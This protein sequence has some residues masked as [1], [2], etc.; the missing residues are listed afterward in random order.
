MSETTDFETARAERALAWSRYVTARPSQAPPESPL[1][2]VGS[3]GYCFGEVW[4]RPGLDVR[5]RR[6]ISLACAGLAGAETPI[7]SHIYGALKSGDI[8]FPEM[9]EAILH[10]GVYAG[11]PKASYM[12]QVANECWAQIQSEGGP[13]SQ[14]PPTA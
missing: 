14:A 12:E 10:F 13:V 3:Q 5:A 4:S 7:R 6:F 1:R 8:S 2:T 9:Q 11:L